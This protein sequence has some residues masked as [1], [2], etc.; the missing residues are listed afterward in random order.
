M[1]ISRHVVIARILAAVFVSLMSSASASA[2]TPT[3]DLSQFAHAAWTARQGFFDGVVRAIAQTQD[4]YLW[5]GTELGLVRFDGVRA[6][7]WTFPSNQRLANSS[8]LSL[9]AT[10]DGSLW[11]GTTAGLARWKNGT[12]TQ[13]AEL[14]GVRILALLEDRSGTVW[15]GSSFRAAGANLCKIHDQ[16]LECFGSDGSLGPWVR[17]IVEDP[18]GHLWVHASTGL[19]Q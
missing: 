1:A 10:R 5:L 6:V 15:A 13:Y 7:P 16:S 2:A 4:G 14:A 3:L 11:I 17:A 8:I 18:D 19:W 9:L 12:L